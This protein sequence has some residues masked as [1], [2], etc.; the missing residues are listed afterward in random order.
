M[1][2]EYG[3]KSVKAQRERAKAKRTLRAKRI[4]QSK[5]KK[6]LTIT[7]NFKDFCKALNNLKKVFENFSK[8][9]VNVANDLFNP[10]TFKLNIN[11]INCMNPYLIQYKRGLT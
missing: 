10:K 5:V 4:K 9:V 2:L 7:I 11:R 6:E 8:A 3:T 1:T